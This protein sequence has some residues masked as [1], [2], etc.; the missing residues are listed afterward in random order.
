M[1]RRNSS[2][3]G[4]DDVDAHLSKADKAMSDLQDMHSKQSSAWKKALKHR[5]GAIVYYSKDKHNAGPKK[6][7]K[8]SFEAPVFKGEMDIKGFSP[9]QVFGVV[10]TRNLWD[11]WYKEVSTRPQTPLPCLAPRVL[12]CRLSR[13]TQKGNLVENLS[14]TCSLTYMCVPSSL[15]RPSS[16][17]ALTVSLNRCMQGIAGSS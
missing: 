2:Y 7:G 15:Q 8:G 17:P 13:R 14:D 6:N 9:A 12:T 11:D 10:G 5:S 3:S 16:E 1:S 4:G